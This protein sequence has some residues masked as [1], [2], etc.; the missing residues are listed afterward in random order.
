MSYQNV[1]KPRFFIDYLSYWNSIGLIKNISCN[2]DANITG[3]FLGIAP[4]SRYVVIGSQDVNNNMSLFIDFN[5]DLNH[6]KYIKRLFN[7]F[8]KTGDLRENL[9][10]NHLQIKL[11]LIGF[12]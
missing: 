2:P 8:E 5:E 9:I 6:I 11:E 3:N 12:L 1:L 7:R 10:I 4:S